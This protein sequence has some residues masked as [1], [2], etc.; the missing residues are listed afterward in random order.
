MNNSIETLSL[1]LMEQSEEI[2]EIMEEYQNS[3]KK[4]DVDIIYRLHDVSANLNALSMILTDFMDNDTLADALKPVTVSY[5][6]YRAVMEQSNQEQ[7]T[8]TPG[9]VKGEKVRYIKEKGQED[10]EQD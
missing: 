1:E 7:H 10:N 9:S 6:L 5:E 4:I 2:N 8:E 3:A